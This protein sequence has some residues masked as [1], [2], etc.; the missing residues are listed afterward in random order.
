MGT[1]AL[2]ATKKL[3]SIKLPMAVRGNMQ[4]VA[5][6]AAAAAAAAAVPA[7]MSLTGARHDRE[8]KR[9]LFISMCVI[10]STHT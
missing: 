5:R 1:T 8:M 7:P 10:I 3:T 4:L 9:L 6:R 2:G